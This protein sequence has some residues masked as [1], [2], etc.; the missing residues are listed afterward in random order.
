MFSIWSTVVKFIKQNCMTLKQQSITKVKF[1]F[2]IFPAPKKPSHFDSNRK[3]EQKLEG[4][5]QTEND[6]FRELFQN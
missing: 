3:Q 1:T 5:F 2:F 6:S 4:K